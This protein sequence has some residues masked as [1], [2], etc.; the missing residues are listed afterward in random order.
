MRRPRQELPSCGWCCTT[1]FLPCSRANLYGEQERPRALN[2]QAL[3][4]RSP[5]NHVLHISWDPTLLE[6]EDLFASDGLV[7]HS[8]EAR[9]APISTTMKG[10]AGHEQICALRE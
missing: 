8:P 4:D 5:H 7:M 6:Q 2:L 3:S 1:T 9:W 10:L